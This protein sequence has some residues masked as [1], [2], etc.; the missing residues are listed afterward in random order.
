MSELKE[1]YMRLID[2]EDPSVIM[3]ASLAVSDQ[4]G[5]E[6]E[7][8]V[9]G[10]KVGPLAPSDTL[11]KI[12]A[13]LMNADFE[14]L[15]EETPKQLQG[16]DGDLGEFL[17]M[18]EEQEEQMRAQLPVQPKT[19][20]SQA[21]RNNQPQQYAQQPVKT[22]PVY[23]TDPTS[24]F[25]FKVEDGIAYKKDWVDLSDGREIKVFAI[26]I[27]EGG[28]PDITSSSVVK[29]LDWVRVEQEEEDVTEG[30]DSDVTNEATTN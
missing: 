25:E 28:N 12:Q 23:F 17:T 11:K 2:A 8:G 20:T 18:N 16:F 13:S 24:G 9:M 6:N 14:E 26:N 1:K 7:F 30:E 5:L 15:Y 22:P 19:H 3:Y 4:K 29:V 10:Y 27:N 21:G